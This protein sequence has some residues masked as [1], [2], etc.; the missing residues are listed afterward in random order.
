MT[1]TGIGNG[2]T[3]RGKEGFIQTAVGEGV[4]TDGGG[5]GVEA[6]GIGVDA[7]L[8]REGARYKPGWKGG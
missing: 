8:G 6:N 2:L 7:N 1:R 4:D 3:Q 5:G